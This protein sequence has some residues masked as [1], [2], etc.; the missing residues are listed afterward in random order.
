MSACSAIALIAPLASA[1]D[2]SANSTTSSLEEIVVTAQF[3]KQ[4][5][6]DT[7]V[8]ITAMSAATLEARGQVSIEGIEAQAPNVSLTTGGSFGGN[9]LIAT[10]RGI[11]QTDFNPAVEPGVG[12]Y[13]DDVYYGTLTGSVLDLLDLDRV[14]ILRGPQGTLSGKNSIGGSIKLFT[15][16]PNDE[17]NGYVEVSAGSFKG[18]SIRAASNFTLQK[19]KLYARVSGVSKTRDGYV[20]NLDWACAHPNRTLGFGTQFR[21]DNCVVGTEGGIKYTAGR[22]ALRWLPTDSLEVNFSIDKIKEDSDPP[23]NVIRA[24]FYSATNRR[25]GIVPDGSEYPTLFALAGQSAPGSGPGSFLGQ[26]SFTTPWG[27]VI[28]FGRVLDPSMFVPRNNRY[29]NF[30]SYCNYQTGNCAAHRMTN[31]ATEGALHIDWTLNNNMTL[32]SITSY[33][34]YTSDWGNDSDG[35]PLSLT[36]LYQ[37]LDHH[38]WTEEVRLSGNVGEKFDYTVGGFYYDA[39]TTMYGRIDLGYVNFDF[40]HGPDPVDITT[41]A[42]FANGTYRFTDQLELVAGLR[43]S[44]DKKTY[45]FKRREPDGSAIMP[46]GPGASSNCLIAGVNGVVSSF[47]GSRVDYRAALNYKV[48]DNAMVYAQVASG[49]KGGGVNPRP[50]FD[51]Q[52]QEVKPET[53]TTYEIG[54]KSELLDRSLRFNVAAFYNDYKSLQFVLSNCTGVPGV[55]NGIPCLMTTNAGNAESKGVEVEF[56]YAPTDALKIDGSLSYIDF[57]MKSLFYDIDGISLASQAPFSP[58]WTYSLGA[59]YKISTNA[60]AFIPR[61]DL[62]YQSET[63]AEWI[64]A[65]GNLLEARTLLNG[66]ITWEANED[67]S[68]ALEVKNITDKFYYNQSVDGDGSGPSFATPG[69]PRT[70]TFMIKRKF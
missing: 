55:I 51:D 41:K 38:A 30:A 9:A 47:S 17:A 1:Q 48:T 29:A 68:A 54:F 58:K 24:P 18:L 45:T 12:V 43:Y 70:F 15:Q 56:D 33:R 62:T 21:G 59:Q 7:P 53:L 8:A 23:A 65:P 13:V 16:K 63:Y 34:E 49:F 5:L 46:C 69:L 22:L 6:Q 28:Q 27:Q 60:G 57:K 39:T 42:V 52:A 64:N 66:R 37:R 26:T 50:F 11:G 25:A 10:I 31:D 32:K 2:T 36:N 67:W 20:K 44:D 40:V 4:N 19:D 14:E 35:T 3:K 61:L